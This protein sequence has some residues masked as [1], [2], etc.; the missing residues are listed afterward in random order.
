MKCD[1][2]LRAWERPSSVRCMR[3]INIDLIILPS[4]NPNVRLAMM[5]KR[6]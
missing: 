3:P 1:D 2:D 5:T 4:P 6:I